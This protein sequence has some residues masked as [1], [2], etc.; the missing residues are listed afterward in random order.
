MLTKIRLFEERPTGELFEWLHQRVISLQEHLIKAWNCLS[1]T[2]I[3]V[4]SF[5][6]RRTKPLEAALVI[7]LLALRAKPRSLSKC[8][9]LGRTR[10][11]NNNN[12][13]ANEYNLALNL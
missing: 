6:F 7:Q 2:T 4:V 10:S 1:Q 12:N 8:P 5:V 13:T 9:P 3:P 11:L